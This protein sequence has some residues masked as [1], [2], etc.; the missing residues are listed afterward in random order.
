M[1]ESDGPADNGGDPACWHQRVCRDCGALAED[2]EQPTVCRRCG[3]TE[4][5]D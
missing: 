1:S 5:G 4:F 2:D 3:S